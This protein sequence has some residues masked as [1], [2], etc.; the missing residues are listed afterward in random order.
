M[1]Y[2]IVLI[3]VAAVVGSVI[4]AALAAGGGRQSKC[5]R[6]CATGPPSGLRGRCKLF[7]WKKPF[8]DDC[9]RAGATPGTHSRGH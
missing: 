8:G 4:V 1:N 2:N 9:A 5:C 7:P 3:I 6:V